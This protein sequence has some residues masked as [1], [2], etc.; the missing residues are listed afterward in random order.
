MADKMV[1]PDKD[2][3]PVS[4]ETKAAMASGGES[5]GGDYPNANSGKDPK[6]TGFQSHGGQTEI[7]YHGT[8]QLGDEKVGD[9]NQN[10]TAKTKD[11]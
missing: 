5:Q 9:G 11:K 1:Q 6:Q 4:G 8:G 2:A 10:A 3:K 7:G